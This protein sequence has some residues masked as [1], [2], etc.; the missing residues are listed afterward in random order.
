MKKLA[1]VGS[2]ELS[3][4]LI[5]YFEGTGFGRVVGLFDDFETEGAVKGD[6]PILGKTEDIP[7]L[8][9]K[10]AFDSVAIA[11]GYKHRRFRKEVYEYLKKHH[12]PI[13]TFVHP[14]SHVE[15][16]AVIQEGSVVLV[17]CTIDMNALVGENVFLSSRCFVSHHVKVGAHTFCG[18]GVNLAGNTATGE[19]CFLGINTTS[20]EG[21]RIGTNVQT[22]AGSVVTKDVQDHVLVAGVP[23]VVKKA[24]PF[25]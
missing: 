15:A 9:N 16:S 18:P 14:S 11:V 24:L 3:D 17:N 23:A 22:A 4:R 12:I 2:S 19:C 6:K 21:V 7:A 25:E 10:K 5:Y 8:F 20:V 1:M 13:A